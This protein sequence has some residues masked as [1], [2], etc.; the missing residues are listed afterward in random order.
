MSKRIKYTGLLFIC[1]LLLAGCGRSRTEGNAPGN[2]KILLLLSDGKDTFIQSIGAAA[3]AYASENGIDLTVQEAEDS[4]EIQVQQMKDAAAGGYGAV[5]CIP[6][7]ADISQQLIAAADGLP[8]V[9]VNRCP[10]SNLLEPDQYVYVGSEDNICGK[11][12]AEYL[13]EYFKDKKS[14]KAVL[15]QGVKT[16]AAAINRTEAVKD[17]LKEAGLQVEYVFEDTANWRRAEAKDMFEIFLDLDREFDC[18]I[19]N[20][21]DMAL[22]VIDACKESG[23]NSSAFPVVGVDATKDGCQAVKDGDLDFTV[24]QSSEGQG[25][26]SVEAARAIMEGRGIKKLPNA[27][28][29]SCYIWIPYE[30]VDRSSLK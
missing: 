21:D 27:S 4:V 15:L 22:G 30:K 10:E 12:Q 7:A 24:L 6:T 5:I 16:D 13:A 3:A 1:M 8:V 18:V 11:Y 25:Q 19:C 23:I 2:Q 14:I 9:F 20:N 17:G 26:M 28:E 29:D